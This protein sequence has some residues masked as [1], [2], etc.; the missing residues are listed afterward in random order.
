MGNE[1]LRMQFSDTAY[2]PSSG[3]SAFGFV[4]FHNGSLVVVGAAKGPRTFSAKE[5]ETRLPFSH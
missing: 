4:M 5:A 3:P 1:I 2:N